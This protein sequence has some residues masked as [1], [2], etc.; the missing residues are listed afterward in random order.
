M[1]LRYFKIIL[2]LSWVFF[3]ISTAVDVFTEN[4]LPK[5]LY[6]YIQQQDT[7][8]IPLAGYF[9][10]GLLIILFLTSY[11]GIYLWQ[12]WARFL[13]L[14]TFIFG[15][16]PIP[17]ESDFGPSV[18]SNYAQSV[19]SLSDILIGVVIGMMFFSMDVVKRFN[20]KVK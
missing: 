12:N 2:T 13:F 6:D 7:L 5:E 8:E 1:I 10:G 17:I 16:I 19:Y 11:I 18:Y 9:F 14:F 15:L 20:E 3:F 4:T